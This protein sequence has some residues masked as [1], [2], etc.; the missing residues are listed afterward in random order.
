MAKSRELQRYIFKNPTFANK[1]KTSRK[2]LNNYKQTIKNPYF[3][4]NYRNSQKQYKSKLNSKITKN[5]M[6]ELPTHRLA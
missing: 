2:P 4:D 6:I 5:S 3:K 1:I